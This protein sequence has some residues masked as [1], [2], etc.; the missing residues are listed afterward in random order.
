MFLLEAS[1]SIGT[2]KLEIPS[3]YTSCKK[4]ET[5]LTLGTTLTPPPLKK[6]TNYGYCL[7]W[8]ACTT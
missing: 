7:E 4:K 5:L 3:G 1:E 6:G 8:F 2:F